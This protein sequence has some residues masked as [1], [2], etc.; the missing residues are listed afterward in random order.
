MND[1]RGGFVR[2]D[3]SWPRVSGFNHAVVAGLLTE[4]PVPDRQ[5]STNGQAAWNVEIFLLLE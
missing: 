2:G 4:P 3:C 5:V 1:R